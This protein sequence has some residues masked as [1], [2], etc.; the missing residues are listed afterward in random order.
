M[1][2]LKKISKHLF[3]NW[4]LLLIGIMVVNWV[5]YI[6]ATYGSTIFHSKREK[7]LINNVELQAL[8]TNRN[9]K[10][11]FDVRKRNDKT[12]F[13]SEEEKW[14]IHR[15]V[16]SVG[17]DRKTK[18]TNVRKMPS[19][20]TL[21]AAAVD[22]RGILARDT[23]AIVDA[24]KLPGLG[25]V[26]IPNN[27]HN[28]EAYGS[29]PVIIKNKEALI[30]QNQ[31]SQASVTK[32]T[33]A[34]TSEKPSNNA[35][36]NRSDNTPNLTAYSKEMMISQRVHFPRLN[37]NDS[38]SVQNQNPNDSF[39][40]SNESQ[41]LDLQSAGSELPTNNSNVL[42]TGS[43]F[44]PSD[45]QVSENGSNPQAKVSKPTLNN[46]KQIPNESKSSPNNNAKPSLH[47]F[48]PS[49][50][51]LNKS[52][53]G[54]QQPANDFKPQPTNTKQLIISSPKDLNFRTNHSKALPVDF[55]QP[56]KDDRQQPNNLEATSVGKKPMVKEALPLWENQTWIMHL[57]NDTKYSISK[58]AG[59]GTYLKLEIPSYPDRKN[60]ERGRPDALHRGT[61]NFISRICSKHLLS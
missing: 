53:K 19:V 56:P 23:K 13:H 14:L 4:I 30:T 46:F 57:Q 35:S 16:Q 43:K 15:G 51:E 33:V 24:R 39:L 27:K 2:V 48:K 18:E 44:S 28:L 55:K 26:D 1:K 5:L 40:E 32:S 54:S 3:S 41:N 34:R 45:L 8:D 9:I 7:H 6:Y 60:Q 37:I 20:E 25:T 47:D 50:K 59:S 61:G 31:V 17:W 38:Q 11:G 58:Q 10:D 29:K 12:I 21:D 36:I 49:P 42:T 22:N 52:S